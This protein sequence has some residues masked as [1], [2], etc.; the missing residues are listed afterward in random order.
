MA[1][2]TN[3]LG[4]HGLVWTGSWGEAACRA[5]VERTRRAGYDVIEVPVLDPATVDG[6]MT[7]EVAAEHGL[8]TT[9]TLGLDPASDISSEDP[10]TVRAGEERLH[11]ALEVA[12]R[13]GG[14]YLGGVIYSAM[15]KYTHLATPLGRK[16][17]VG[18][19]RG[20]ADAAADAGITVGLEP[21]NRYESNL[22][23]TVD[24]ALALIDEIGADNVVV[25]LDSYH[26]NIEERDLASPV[27]RAAAAG[28]LGYVHVGESHR[29]YLGSGSVD[30]TTLFRALHDVGY[31]GP[32]VFESF[33]SAIVSEAFTAALG[34]WREP[35]TDSEDLA[36]HA[37]HVMRSHLHVAAGQPGRR[38][39]SEP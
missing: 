7:R 15:A 10:G 30:L 34:I 1:H 9:F 14:D 16:H 39:R 37:L 2:T 20:L 4:I 23:N 31:E 22:V 8:A 29:G 13:G 35:W 32:I 21:V 3:P 38:E 17:A 33:S 24:Q 18:V 12:R 28:R 36:T 27:F 5:A 25:H 11:A 6:D 26:M 19:L